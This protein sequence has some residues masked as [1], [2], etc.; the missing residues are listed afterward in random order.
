MRFAPSPTG[1]L[2]IG[3]ARTALYNWLFAKANNGTF[4]LRI[5]DTD[6]TRSTEEA[7]KAILDGMEWLGLDWNEGPDVGG[8]FGP[9][10]QTQRLDTYKEWADK[11]LAEGKAYYCFCTPEELAEQRRIAAEKKEAPKYGGKCRNL[12]KEE[13]ARRQESGEPCVIRFKLPDTGVTKV[14]DLIR[15]EVSFENEVLDDFVIVKSDGFPTY[16]F[17]AV[18]DDNL[19]RITHVIRGDDHLSNTPRQILL[20]KAFGLT[21]PQF[22]HIPMIMGQDK[23][24]L[25]KRHGA[26]SVIEYKT[27][28]YLPEAVVN[29]IARLGWGHRDQEIFS[30]QEL[31]DLFRLEKVSKTPAIFDFN[32]LNW[33][34]AHY[35]KTSEL[36]RI[37]GL[38]L[39]LIEAAYPNVNRHYAHKVIKSLQERLKVIPDIVPLSEYF[40]KDNFTV[41]PEAK[42]KYLD[43]PGAKE[44]IAKLRARIEKIDHM[45][46]ASL[47]A[48]FKSLAEE[49]KVKLGEII[50]P[51]RVMLTGRAESPG[52]YEVI[53]VLGKEKTLKRLADL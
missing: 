21:P 48:A 47:E 40:F 26:T 23:A 14:R 28:G 44:L 17:A 38:C 8:E 50:H 27:M 25:S 12:K 1:F 52:I 9:Y 3:G 45:D 7:V 42:A 36:D 20:Y 41:E 49:A 33:L 39:P 10:F 19:M 37:V 15:G 24:R 2:H 30:R 31:I 51:V 29:Y 53:E 16:N 5:E 32:K 35:I 34:N 13:A 4:I 22:A 11:L 43:K 6:R 46:H 18:V